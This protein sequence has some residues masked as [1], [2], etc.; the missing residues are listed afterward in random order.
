MS[1]DEPLK[2]LM[3]EWRALSESEARSVEKSDWPSVERCQRQKRNLQPV[4]ARQARLSGASLEDP[5][6]SPFI[7]ELFE[8]NI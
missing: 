6:S 4:M 7:Q 3:D 1:L 2:S 8:S 5:R